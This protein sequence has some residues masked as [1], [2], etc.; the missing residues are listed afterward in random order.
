MPTTN[1]RG[2][3]RAAAGKDLLVDLL[4]DLG[5]RFALARLGEVTIERQLVAF[6]G[7]GSELFKHAFSHRARFDSPSD[8]IRWSEILHFGRGGSRRAW[9]RTAGIDRPDLEARARAEVAV[10]SMLARYPFSLADRSKYYVARSDE[11]T[12]RGRSLKRV[13]LRERDGRAEV[14]GPEQVD[15][16]TDRI[17]VYVDPRTRLPVLLEIERKGIGRRRI[18]FAQWRRVRNGPLLPH[19]RIF[20]G[21]DGESRALVVRWSIR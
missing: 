2:P 11:I 4:E 14:I 18:G 9:A 20:Y 5:G 8:E 21:E 17:D 13:R 15:E 3:T 7:D 12:L 10:W 1:G 6:A 19:E 16:S